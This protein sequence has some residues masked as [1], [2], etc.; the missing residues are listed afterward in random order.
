M[1]YEDWVHIDVIFNMF[2]KSGIG[3]HYGAYTTHKGDSF[4]GFL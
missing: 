4:C 1:I 3:R 2:H